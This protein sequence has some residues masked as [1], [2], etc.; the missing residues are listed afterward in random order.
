MFH[1]TT[2]HTSRHT[3]TVVIVTHL[4]V[5]L[6]V[7]FLPRFLTFSPWGLTSAG[8]TNLLFVS[9]CAHR[10]VASIVS[11]TIHSPHKQGHMQLTGGH[12]VCRLS[13]N[14][15]TALASLPVPTETNADAWLRKKVCLMVSSSLHLQVPYLSN[16]GS[17]RRIRLAVRACFL[18][19]A[20]TQADGD[21]D[22]EC[23]PEN[24]LQRQLMGTE[25]V[26]D[27]SDVRMP[28]LYPC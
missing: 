18:S 12:L 11:A 10:T 15:R 14:M 7:S 19:E 13:S 3:P 28:T 23:H 9:S 27:T 24:L 26:L 8:H 22:P 17:H 2:R 1:S 25:R 4:D 20:V 16:Q 21:Q 5:C 6:I